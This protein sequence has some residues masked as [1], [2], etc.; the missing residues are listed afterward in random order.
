MS[1]L[2]ANILLKSLK[3]SVS[4]TNTRAISCT[5][6]LWAEP[7]RKK[8]R[9]DPAML[10]KQVERKIMKAKREITRLESQPKQPIALTEYQYSP[11][12]LRDLTARP[13]HS[14]EEFNISLSTLRGA[15]RLWALYRAEQDR[16]ASKSVDKVVRAQENALKMM[17]VLDQDLYNR[18]VAIDDTVLIPYNSDHM[19]R[20]TPPNPDY[21]PPDGNVTDVTKE[22]V[23]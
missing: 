8:K 20:E 11:S 21:Q 19:R 7:P 15:Q 6:A 18:T 12:E 1:S 4:Y 13:K 10:K 16:M 23:M 5:P 9:I 14:M 17:R 2:L 22:Y 3:K